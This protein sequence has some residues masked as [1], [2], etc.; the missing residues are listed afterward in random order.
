MADVAALVRQL[1]A[2]EYTKREEATKRLVAMGPAA[3]AQLKAALQA[4]RLELEGRTRA[5]YILG[6]VDV[7]DCGVVWRGG[8]G[9]ERENPQG[10]SLKDGDVVIACDDDPI[11][12]WSDISAALR[13]DSQVQLKLWRRG[14]GYI[15]ITLGESKPLATGFQGW[16]D[17]LELFDRFAKS[18]KYD[19]Q[20]RQAIRLHYDGNPKAAEMFAQAWQAGCRKALVAA[21]WLD[22]LEEAGKLKQARQ[23]W[24]EQISGQK[25]EDFAGGFWQYGMLPYHLAGLEIADGNYKGARDVLDAALVTARKA[26]AFRG[27]AALLYA[28]TEMK[29]FLDEPAEAAKFWLANP[30]DITGMNGVFGTDLAIWLAVRLAATSP[31]DALKFIDTWGDSPSKKTLKEYYTAQAELAAKSAASRPGDKTH[32]VLVKY[33]PELVSLNAPLDH[34]RHNN[35][36]ELGSYGRLVVQMRIASFPPE[37]TRWARVAS[38][39]LSGGGSGSGSQ[40]DDQEDPQEWTRAMTFHLSSTGCATLNQPAVPAA[41]SLYSPSILAAGQWHEVAIDAL[42]DCMAVGIDGR[43]WRR[44]RMAPWKGRYQASIS[45][46]GAGAE[47]R[48]ATLYVASSVEID[49]KLV[50]EQLKAF[51]AARYACDLKAAQ[52]IAAKL[53]SAWE[54]VPEAAEYLAE[55]RGQL[56]D[57]ESFM[58]PQGLELC[59][60]D[61]LKQAKYEE[62]FWRLDGDSL[63]GS[64][65]EQRQPSLTLTLPLRNFELSGQLE[66]TQPGQNTG[67]V[68]AWGSPDNYTTTNLLGYW[69]PAKVTQMGIPQKN[70][71]SRLRAPL[72][73]GFYLRTRGDKAIVLAADGKRSGTVEGISFPGDKFTLY[74]AALPEGSQAIYRGLRIRHLADN[75]KL[76]DPPGDA[77]AGPATG[78]ATGAVSWGDE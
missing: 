4:G 72:E 70:V 78:P 65:Q 73:K 23:V 2:D 34:Y 57:F 12:C 39:H 76:E 40:S 38:V 54:K 77:P 15:S 8:P 55:F 27:A 44:T 71:S 17:A 10:E 49:N 6:L 9:A 58:S 5:E 51:T 43:T 11:L 53:T 63:I 67:I 7:P 69:L 22:E 60:A 61:M 62:K 42:P 59:T 37:R 26:D 20:V 46:S 50:L 68:I 47:F 31:D 13:T 24:Q 33:L 3:V 66:V 52:A 45:C 35:I 74:T 56:R 19:Q 21:L 64:C 1:D 28:Q 75:V 14:Q 18:D 25:L 29:V 41:L 36:G 16:P 48:E 32:L 30:H